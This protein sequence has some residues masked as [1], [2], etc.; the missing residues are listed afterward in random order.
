VI[1]AVPMQPTG[2]PSGTSWTLST[3]TL[4]SDLNAQLKTRTSPQAQEQNPPEATNLSPRPNPS[5]SRLFHHGQLRSVTTMPFAS[6]YSSFEG[7]QHALRPYRP[8]TQRELNRP[9]PGFPARFRPRGHSRRLDGL[10]RYV[11]HAFTFL[12]PFTHT[13]FPCSRATMETL[14][15]ALLPT[16]TSAALNVP[17]MHFPAPLAATTSASCP[18]LWLT[19]RVEAGPSAR[20]IASPCLRTLA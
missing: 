8:R 14:T 16:S 1:T 5:P 20:P 9:G 2:A 10:V 17:L 4:R 13:A 15:A 7:C 11:L 18:V 12:S 3:K 19:C 6:C